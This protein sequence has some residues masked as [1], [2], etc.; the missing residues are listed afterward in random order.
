[1]ATDLR[2]VATVL[3][4]V[5]TV[6]KFTTASPLALLY[7]D[8]PAEAGERM[9]VLSEAERRGALCVQV[10]SSAIA[11][12]LCRDAGEADGAVVKR[13]RANEVPPAG[14][15][16]GWAKM[17][18]PR[19]VSFAG[20]LCGT[21]G[22]LADAERMLHA[23]VPGVRPARDRG[24]C[25]HGGRLGRPG[26]HRSHSMCGPCGPSVLRVAHAQMALAR[27]RPR[28]LAWWKAGRSTCP[29]L[30]LKRR[31]RLACRREL[32]T[33]AAGRPVGCST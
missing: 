30:P 2:L 9:S 32:R 25:A 6:S 28:P 1:M 31:P 20:V 12:M 23:L 18:L 33:R 15:E 29:Q 16:L 3:C 8:P 19:D 27:E 22:G 24:T 4:F 7:V 10:H 26:T 17:V 11:S 21:D 13:V 14:E 5:C